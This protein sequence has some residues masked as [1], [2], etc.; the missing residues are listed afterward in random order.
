[1]FQPFKNKHQ[2]KSNIPMDDWTP[3]PMSV[4]QFIRLEQDNYQYNT[5]YTQKPTAK[6]ALAAK[7]N[8]R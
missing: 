7:Q 6:Q 2:L 3:R 5:A 4:K 1:M 8:R